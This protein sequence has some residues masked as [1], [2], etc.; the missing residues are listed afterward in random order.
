M[1][2]IE[3]VQQR[4]ITTSGATRLVVTRRKI[5]LYCSRTVLNLPLGRVELRAVLDGTFDYDTGGREA[6]VAINAYKTFDFK[7]RST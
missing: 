7:K 3:S 2:E 5:G 1:Y 6:V 4:E